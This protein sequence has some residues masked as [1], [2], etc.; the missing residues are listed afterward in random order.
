VVPAAAILILE[1]NQVTR[2]VLPRIASSVV[3]E[4]ERHERRRF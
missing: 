2:M 1:Q 3:Q 4:H